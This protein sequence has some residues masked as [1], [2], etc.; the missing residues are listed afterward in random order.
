M[1]SGAHIVLD[2]PTE[3]TTVAVLMNGIVPL[4][5]GLIDQEKKRA[6]QQ[7][8]E[9][10]TGP[11]SLAEL[12]HEEG[13]H[14]VKS[15]RVQMKG[16]ELKQYGPGKE[17]AERAFDEAVTGKSKRGLVAGFEDRNEARK[18]FVEEF[19]RVVREEWGGK[20][21]KDGNWLDIVVAVKE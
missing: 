10:V 11:K 6:L 5:L 16:L 21:F 1:K 20:E 13:F 7:W 9:W 3:R 12:V 15:E 8:L 19:E 2:V 14:L 4:R 18:V 17:D